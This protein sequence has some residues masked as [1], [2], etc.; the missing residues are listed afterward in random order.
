[1]SGPALNQVLNI[2][3]DFDLY[4]FGHNSPEYVHHL[5]EAIKLTMAD[6]ETYYSD[7]K[8]VDVPIER[9]LDTDTLKP[10]LP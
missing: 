5:I 8:F 2:V 3:K 9:L 6:R 10:A 4:K 1:M 7:P